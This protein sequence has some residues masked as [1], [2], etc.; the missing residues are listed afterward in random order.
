MFGLIYGLKH[1]N[2]FISFVN[3][4]QTAVLEPI[5][6]RFCN[7]VKKVL[8]NLCLNS[9]V[10]CNQKWFTIPKRTKTRLINSSSFKTVH[11]WV[12]LLCHLE[13]HGKKWPFI[14]PHPHGLT[15]RVYWFIL[16]CCC[17]CFL[18]IHWATRTQQQYHSFPS[19]SYCYGQIVVWVGRTGSGTGFI[20]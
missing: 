12:Y 2:L 13:I 20:A 4:E 7:L 14:P 18:S 8:R 5:V 16:I 11:G 1:T 19:I 15:C 9:S 6:N 10:M 17:D 3:G